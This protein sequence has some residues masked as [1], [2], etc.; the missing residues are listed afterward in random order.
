M[1]GQNGSVIP[2]PE[3]GPAQSD[4]GGPPAWRAGMARAL[5]ILVGSASAVVVVA[6]VQATAWL[7]G[8]AFMALIVV[9]AVAPVHGWLRR[10]GWPGWVTTLVLI[11][12]VYGILLA[13]ALQSI[14]QPRFIGDAVGLSVTLTFVV[15][16]S[17]HGCSAR[18]GRSWPSRSRCWP[19]PCSWTSTRRLSG[20]TPCCGHREGAGTGGGGGPGRTEE[21]GAPGTA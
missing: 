4:A 7:I 20:L 1:I 19:R 18:W 14:I 13:L 17:G 15:C 16:S 3:A 21:H 2:T 10:H 11:L 6:G 5:V 8:P 9:I 12:L